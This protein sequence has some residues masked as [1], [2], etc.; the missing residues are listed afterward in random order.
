[1]REKDTLRGLLL[2]ISELWLSYL[3]EYGS[4]NEII[5][6]TTVVITIVITNIS[7]IIS[8]IINQ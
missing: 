6:T 5:I 7:I 8:M 2:A 3:I 4:L 1:M